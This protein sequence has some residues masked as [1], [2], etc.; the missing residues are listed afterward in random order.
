MTPIVRTQDLTKLFP[1][2]G[3]TFAALDRITFTLAPAEFTAIM[4]PSG[5]G[6]ST[7]MN[8]IGCLDRAT[9]GRYEFDGADISKLSSNDL[10][11]LRRTKLGFVFQSYNLLPRTSALENVEL[12]MVYAPI[13][14]RERRRRARRALTDV[15]LPERSFEQMPNE[16]SGGQQQRIAIARALVN[17]PHLVLADEPTGA[18]DSK[19]SRDIMEL[20][21]RLNRERGLTILMVTHEA[22]VA[23]YSRRIVSFFDGRIVADEPVEQRSLAVAT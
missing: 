10:A 21:V 19:T 7:F 18:L 8:I 22:D 13:S 12:P 20:F 15:G 23:R 6:K 2:G 17:E 5:S 1:S 16:L 11:D 3:T 9:S 14:E 4:G